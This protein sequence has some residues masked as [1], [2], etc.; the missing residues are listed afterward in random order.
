MANV[1]IFLLAS[2]L[3]GL[4]FSRMHFHFSFNFTISRSA[5]APLNVPGK[6]RTAGKILGEES[7]PAVRSISHQERMKSMQA[8]FVPSGNK[9]E[10]DLISALMNL[11]CEKGKALKLAKQAIGQAPDFEGRVKWALQNAA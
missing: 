1:L 10:S 7:R 4:F 3:V 6:A 11:G 9:Q 8:A 2:A 5:K